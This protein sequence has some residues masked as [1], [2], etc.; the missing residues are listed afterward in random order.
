MAWRKKDGYLGAVLNSEAA[1]LKQCVHS[2]D[3]SFSSR[4]CLLS[5]PNKHLIKV[6]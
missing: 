1:D 3:F 4:G 2:C 6:L 5:L